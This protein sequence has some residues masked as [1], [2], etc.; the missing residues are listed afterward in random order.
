MKNQGQNLTERQFD[1]SSAAILHCT[2][3]FLGR[4]YSNHT[5]SYLKNSNVLQNMGKADI[6]KLIGISITDK[7]I[8]M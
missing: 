1:Y 8:G 5:D 6:L 2:A 7:T 3:K 4:N